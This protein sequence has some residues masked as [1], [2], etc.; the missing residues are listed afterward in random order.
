MLNLRKK[1]QSL[2][3]TQQNII[4]VIL[5]LFNLA[6]IVFW[7][8]FWIGLKKVSPP[9]ITEKP[10]QA[11]EIAGPF[12]KGEIGEISEKEAKEKGISPLPPAVFNT[13]GKILEIKSDRLIVQ[14]S[15]S[16]FTDQKP[17]TLT[18]IFTDSTT[19]Y[20]PKTKFISQGLAGLKYLKT[21]MEISIESSG[22]IRGKTELQ[23]SSI[24]IL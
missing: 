4:T 13:S 1:I 7:I 6:V 12:K 17:R 14:G 21:G 19:V 15:G 18:L 11:E 10:K 3:Q 9:K 8:N 22:N 24:N 20:D 2:N 5:I 23:V 16:N